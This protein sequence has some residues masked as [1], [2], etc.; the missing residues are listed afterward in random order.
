MSELR[1]WLWERFFMGD[2]NDPEKYPEVIKELQIMLKGFAIK[3]DLYYV[4]D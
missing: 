1:G 3:Y 2:D 4:E